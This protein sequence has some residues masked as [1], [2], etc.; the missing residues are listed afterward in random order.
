MIGSIKNPNRKDILM[1]I[2]LLTARGAIV[3]TA[4]SLAALAVM[5]SLAP[6]GAESDIKGT[7]A[8]R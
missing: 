2:P 3:A 6:A 1:P 4:G 5:A 7:I 8:I